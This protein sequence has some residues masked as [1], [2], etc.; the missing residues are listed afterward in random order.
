MKNKK[1]TIKTRTFILSLNIIT[2][3]SVLS[4]CG[5]KE[6]GEIPVG[7][8]MESQKPVLADIRYDENLDGDVPVEFVFSDGTV[9]ERQS[10]YPVMDVEYLDMTGDGVDEVL[11]KGMFHDGMETEDP[12]WP[13]HSTLD[14]FQIDGSEA[15]ELSFTDD[16]EELQGKVCEVHVFQL[17]RGGRKGNALHVRAYIKEN[18]IYNLEK[19]MDI[20][21]ENG[22]WVKLPKRKFE[23]TVSLGSDSEDVFSFQDILETI[24]S[25]ARARTGWPVDGVER[26]IY[27]LMD[28][29]SDGELELVVEVLGVHIYSQNDDSSVIMVFRHS[30]GKL[31][32]IYGVNTWARSET[33]ILSD[34][35]IDGGGSGG[36][37]LHCWEQGKIGADGV[38]REA[39]YLSI[40]SGQAVGEMEPC[41]DFQD[42][43]FS[44]VF[45]Q[46]KM[47]GE[48]IYAY[49]IEEDT[50]EELRE[51]VLEYIGENEKNLGVEFLT[52]EKMDALRNARIQELGISE[53]NDEDKQ[54]FWQTLNGCEDYLYEIS[55]R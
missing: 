5:G 50:P 38:Y 53:G 30:D 20:F 36:A 19:E 23:P 43:E 25:D 13:Y 37:T 10:M 9:V 54:I 26:V 8:E 31:E 46:C 48:T 32:L 45:Y 40:G 17:D 29:G 3:F 27:G 16:I 39:Y 49:D 35:S 47:E 42:I 15:V 34:G 24:I 1:K 22:K 33:H 11:L 7:T 51:D 14:I 4:S 55:A 2:L 18:L 44:P 21:Y 52:Y 41:Y 28:C 6:K 12:A